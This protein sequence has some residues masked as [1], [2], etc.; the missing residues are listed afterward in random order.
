MGPTFET[1]AEINML[2][3]IGADVVGM[4][5]VSEIILARHAGLKCA[6]LSVVVNFAA[7]LVESVRATP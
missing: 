1:P 3:A 6:G 5:T 7:G 2:K 4:S